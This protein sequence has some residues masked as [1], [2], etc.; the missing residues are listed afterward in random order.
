MLI[1]CLMCDHY[2]LF[3][4]K[5]RAF[6]K[7]IP[8]QIYRGKIDHSEPYPEDQGIVF[9][10][11]RIQEEEA[12]KTQPISL[13]SSSEGNGMKRTL[14]FKEKTR[15]FV[16]TLEVPIPDAILARRIKRKK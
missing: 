13:S 10:P 7:G 6:P 14:V 16:A 1:Q 8:D 4:R 12:P 5:C 3:Q 9:T 11:L 15:K 2:Y